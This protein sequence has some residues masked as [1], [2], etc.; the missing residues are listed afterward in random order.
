[1]YGTF[2]FEEYT[3]FGK[4]GT[5]LDGRKLRLILN[6]EGLPWTVSL[7]YPKSK[8]KRILTLRCK[9]WVG[10]GE[11]PWMFARQELCAHLVQLVCLER[12]PRTAWIRS[13]TYIPI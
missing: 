5:G 1:V 10:A 6:K 12:R 2:P 13:A 11:M 9:V 7:F 8:R 3:V 4:E